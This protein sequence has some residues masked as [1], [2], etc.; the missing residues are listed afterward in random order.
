MIPRQMKLVASH[1]HR[2]L[3]QRRI[4][5]VFMLSSRRADPVVLAR[6]DVIIQL[7]L[8]SIAYAG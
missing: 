3:R 7:L 1:V 8:T 5:R 2:V 4:H 6:C